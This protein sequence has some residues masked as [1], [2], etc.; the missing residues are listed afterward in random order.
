MI[1]HDR[2]AGT[3]L[4]AELPTRHGDGRSPDSVIVITAGPGP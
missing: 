4:A 1:S 2:V 3:V